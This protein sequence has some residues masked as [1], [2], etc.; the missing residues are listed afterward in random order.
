[1]DDRVNGAKRRRLGLL[2]L[3]LVTLALAVGAASC[4]GDDETAAPAPPAE[5]AEPPAEPAEPPAEPSEPPAEP[6]E[7]PAE[8][9]AE[10]ECPAEDGVIN[11]FSASDLESATIGQNISPAAFVRMT[12]LYLEK[13]NAEG[14]ILG[15]QVEFTGAED[16]FV[17]DECLRLY[18]E[19]LQSNEYDVYF[20]PTNSGC[21]A[22]LPD[23]IGAAGKFLISG[24]AADHQPF[25]SD[26]SQTSC[27]KE[28]YYVAHASVSTFLEGRASAKWAA[29][30][31]WMRPALIVPNY[32]YG[33]DVGRGFKDYYAQLVPDGQIVDEQFPE[34]DEDDFTPFFNALLAADPDGILSAFFSTSIVPMMNQWGATGRDGEIPV[35]SGLANL[36]FNN[37]VT[38]PASLPE[39]FYGY[40]RGNWSL[41]EGNPVAKE[42]IDLWA[43]AYGEEWG[44]VPDSFPFQVLSSWT[45][46][47]A[48]VEQT[49]SL[50]PEAWK[51]LIESGTFAFEGP[52][53]AGPTYV[54]PINHMADTC[55][56][57]GLV[58]FDEE[59]GTA[60]YDASTWSVSC[61]KDVLPVEEAQSLTENPNVTPEAIAAYQEATGTP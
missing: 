3:A 8:P 26:C 22:G 36:D 52:Y 41:L 44:P 37:A 28:P 34:F 27:F 16:G 11:V 21:M 1:V 49:G 29:D 25:F 12:N 5:P 17:I 9:P 20:G 51:T 31:G 61:M 47:E 24:I 32:A 2:L 14:G 7:P 18:R 33:Q 15:C 4:G 35:I 39:N 45:M 48:L 58:V 55:A 57:V 13:V 56:S 23:L 40:D 19:A 50:D 54:N 53:N 42:Y 59:L 46:L 43:A 30:Q 38:D 6:A 10:A 60:T